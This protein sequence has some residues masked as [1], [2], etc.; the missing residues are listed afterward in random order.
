MTV[1]LDAFAAEHQLEPLRSGWNEINQETAQW[2]M[3]RMLSRGL[4]YRTEIM[5]ERQ[6]RTLT[7]GF[8]AACARDASRQRHRYYT[9]GKAQ[10]S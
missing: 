9:N 8:M 10:V 1:L 7:D 3:V 5:D 2:I 6:A 4:A